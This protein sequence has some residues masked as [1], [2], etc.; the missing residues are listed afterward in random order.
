MEITRDPYVTPR[1][2]CVVVCCADKSGPELSRDLINA[3][4][5]RRRIGVEIYVGGISDCVIGIGAGRPPTSST[6]LVIRR[7]NYVDD[8]TVL[9]MANKSAS[10]LDRRL[11]NALRAGAI[12]IVRF[13]LLD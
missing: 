9:V 8:A 10:D 3:V 1:G 5:G 12:A 2:D 4:V 11:V 13:Y 7:S 6:R